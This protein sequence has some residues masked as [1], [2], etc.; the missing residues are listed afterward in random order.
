MPNPYLFQKPVEQPQKLRFWKIIWNGTKL[1]IY[2]N[3]AK[4]FQ[5]PTFYINSLNNPKNEG[6]ENQ[7]N[8]VQNC[9]FV[10]MLQ[11]YTKIEHLTKTG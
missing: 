5:V 4:R 11:S 8:M 3:D 9:R 1:K 2:K 10:K 7:A 6:F